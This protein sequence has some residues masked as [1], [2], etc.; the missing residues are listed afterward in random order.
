VVTRLV[1]GA[2]FLAAAVLNA[3]A[4]M[5]TYEVYEIFAFNPAHRRAC[6]GPDCV[7]GR[8]GRTRWETPTM[9]CQARV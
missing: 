9:A 8:K 3:F 5:R 6:R 2:G 1:M 4:S 7:A